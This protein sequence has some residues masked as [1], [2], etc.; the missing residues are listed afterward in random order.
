MADEEN[1]QVVIEGEDASSSNGSARRNNDVDR[2][3]Q[4]EAARSRLA[5]AR[6]ARENEMNRV[7]NE[8]LTWDSESKAAEADLAEAA[9]RGDYQAQAR[10][11][12]RMS[13]AENRKLQAEQRAE[14]LKRAPVS[15]GDPLEDHLSRF[16]DRSAAWM[17]E[18]PDW[19]TDPRKNAKLTGAH[20]LAISEG[21]TP[22][23]DQYEAFVEK[24]IGLRGNG[25]GGNRGGGNSGGSF[26]N[27]INRGDYNTHVTDDGRVFL[28]ENEK[29][30]S[31]DGTIVFN[32]GPNKGQ[33]IGVKEMARRKAE[34]VRAGMH[35]R[36]G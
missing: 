29:R 23:T 15:S 18:H 27:G 8:V 5:A 9:D 12:R 7:E 19:V 16:T 13:V 32:T 34:Q 10:A 36:L 35:N 4:G 22:D 21:L 28:T 25:N 2:H 17:R 3:A 33:P 1:F 30:I 11:N 14:Y 26:M 24:T 6:M 20:H 31:Q